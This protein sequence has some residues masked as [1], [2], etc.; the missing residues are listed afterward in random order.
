MDRGVG[1]ELG[2][3]AVACLLLAAW[4]PSLLFIGHWQIP[5]S[6]P[7]P[8]TQFSLGGAG[9]SLHA[10]GDHAGHCHSDSA[11][12]SQAPASPEAPAADLR[13]QAVALG[14]DGLAT[15]AVTATWR[16]TPILGIGP[17]LRPPRA[18]SL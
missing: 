11:R 5:V 10:H 1:A 6:I 13:E 17:E 9:V 2:S 8:G 7:I 14:L 16:P 15:M 18:S 3:P 4:L 12:C